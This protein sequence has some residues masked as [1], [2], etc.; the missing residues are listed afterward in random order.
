M[1]PGYVSI[2]VQAQSILSLL[3][4]MTETLSS[5]SFTKDAAALPQL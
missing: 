4:P 2:V 1:E 3:S 5:L